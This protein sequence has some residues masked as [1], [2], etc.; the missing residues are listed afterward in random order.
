M[1]RL[2]RHEIADGKW[3]IT[4]NGAKVVSEVNPLLDRTAF[5]MMAVLAS[6]WLRHELLRQTTEELGRWCAGQ[7]AG[8]VCVLD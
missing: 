4:R 7:H 6:H 2:V 5:K 1:Q 3:T 8:F